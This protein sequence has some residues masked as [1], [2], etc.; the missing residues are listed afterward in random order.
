VHVLTICSRNTATDNIK[1]IRRKFKS[2]PST[3]ILPTGLLFKV[4][5]KIH[6]RLILRIL[7]YISPCPWGSPDAEAGRESARLRLILDSLH[8]LDKSKPRQTFVAGG[9]VQW[10]PIMI[11]EDGT[12]AKRDTKL[13]G[14]NE[15]KA[16]LAE[17]QPPFKFKGVFRED[18]LLVDLTKRTAQENMY[19][20]RKNVG[21]GT[22]SLDWHAFKHRGTPQNAAKMADLDIGKVTD[23]PPA[24]TPRMQ[25]LWDNRFL[26]DF[27]IEATQR[28]LRELGGAQVRVRYDPFKYCLPTL[29]FTDPNGQERDLKPKAG[30]KLDFVR[31]AFI[32]T[33]D[34][35]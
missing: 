33:F 29:H 10:T 3:F 20:S 6:E 15:H 5:E 30:D 2:P 11:R 19:P 35:P 28:Y 4:P 25:Y 13:E 31:A 7:R 9:W 23:A 16:W 14:Q 21:Q 27:D 26:L 8:H 24:D 18:N 34:Q 32:R 22:L 1:R 17:R 12:I